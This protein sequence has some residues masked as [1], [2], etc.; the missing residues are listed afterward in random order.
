MI[1]WFIVGLIACILCLL[2][3]L[4]VFLGGHR[5]RGHG[6]EQKLYSRHMVRPLKNVEDSIKKEV[7]K[8]TITRKNQCLP[9]S[10][11]VSRNK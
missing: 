11:I 6:Y 8:T 1:L 3:F 7:K 9:I 4:V 10:K 5:I 2:F